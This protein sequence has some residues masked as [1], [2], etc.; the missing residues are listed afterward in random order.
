[1]NKNLDNYNAAL[2]WRYATKSFDPSKKIP[3]DVLDGLL[4]CLR[5]TA[6]SFGLQLWKFLI[7]SN[8]EIRANLLAPSYSQSQVVD[9]SHLIVFCRPKSFDPTMIE[10]FVNQTAS[11][12]NQSVESLAPFK[13]YM[14]K[15]TQN[16]SF[17]TEKWMDN[18][19]YIALGNLLSACA[20]AGVD[21]CPM[22]G[23]SKPKYDEVLGLENDNLT[24]V[25]ACPI[26]YRLESDKYASLAKVRYPLEK[27]VSF[28]K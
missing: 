5:L 14:D 17:P 26:G 10:T 13:E 3:Q 6:S 11:T 20:L 9:A 18:Q 19:L 23:F 4:E 28:L 1:M 22:E 25:V 15:A 16:P 21:S 24:A 2:R 8:P 7:I 27:V 12:R